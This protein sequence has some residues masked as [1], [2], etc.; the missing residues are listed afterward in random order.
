M[1]AGADELGGHV[2]SPLEVP[3]LDSS[4]PPGQVQDVVLLER[5]PQFH[6]GPDS[7]SSTLLFPS[8]IFS[9]ILFQIL[10]DESSHLLPTHAQFL[11]LQGN[12]FQRLKLGFNELVIQFQH[13]LIAVLG[14]QLS[15]QFLSC[16]P[17]NIR[18]VRQ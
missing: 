13:C 11:L 18:R 17:Q 6:P 14:L 2:E 9:P 4:C 7:H 10:S 1:R 8:L 12:Q 16:F 5:D 3:F 15:L